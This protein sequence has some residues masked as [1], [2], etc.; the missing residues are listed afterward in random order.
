MS[1]KNN[2]NSGSQQSTWLPVVLWIL[3]LLAINIGLALFSQIDIYWQQQEQIADARQEVEALAAGSDFSY[4]YARQAGDFASAFKSATEVGFSDSKLA[5]FLADRADQVFRKPFPDYELYTFKIP[6]K[7]RPGNLL[8]IKT[9]TQPSRRVMVR[10][11]EHL[12]RVNQGHDISDGAG[13]QNERL[14]SGLFGQDTKSDVLAHSQ[15]GKASFVL[16]RSFP[17]WF[18]WDY[19]KTADGTT[20]GYYLLSQ[21][22]EEHKIAGRLLALRDLRQRGNGLGAFLPLFSGYGGTA[23]QPPLHKSRMFHEWAKNQK[24]IAEK[25]LKQWLESGIPEVARI[26]NYL[27]FSHIGKGQTHLAVF[28][29]PQIKVPKQPLWLYLF[30]MASVSLLLLILLRGILL[31]Q[32]PEF[33]LRFR[34]IMTYL[35]A[36]TLPLSLLIISSYAYIAQYRRATH[37]EILNSLQLSIKQF[38]TRKSQIEDDYRTAFNSIFKDD[39]LGKILV[40]QGSKS[41]AAKAL[42]LHHFENDK[43][44]LPLLC[45]AIIDE[46]GDGT[47]YYGGQTKSEADPAIDTFSYPITL[48][49]REKIKAH[50]PAAKLDKLEASAIQ[51]TSVEAYKSMSRSSLP[52]EMDIRRSFPIKRQ[53]GAKTATQMHDFIWVDGSEKYAVFVVWDDQA[54]DKSTFTNSL[55]QIALNNPDQNFIA[56]KASPQG[57]SFLEKPGRH[58]NGHFINKA[59][60]LATMAQ[61]R[62]SYASRQ[63]NDF[64]L[65]AMPAKKYDQ[66]IIVGG[67]NHFT[68]NRA[69]DHRLFILG[70]I[71][72]LSLAVVILAGYYS[73]RLILDPIETL[74]SAIDKVTGGQLTT[75]IESHS[76]DELGTLCREFSTM[77]IGLRER[78]RLATLL[79]DQAMDA[80][81]KTSS[82]QQILENES[83]SGVALVSDIRNFTGLCEDNP[84]DKVTELLNEHFAGMASIISNHGGRIYKFIGDA[85]EA[86]FPENRNMPEDA[87]TRA[88]NA[89]AMMLLKARQINQLRAKKKLFGYRIGIGLAYGMM[90]SGS[91]GS[92]DTRLDYAIIGEPLKLA[93]KLEALSIHN[94]AFPLIVDEHLN[95]S[96]HGQGLIFKKFDNIDGHAAFSLQEVGGE[97]EAITMLHQKENQNIEASVNTDKIEKFVVDS[98]K[99]LSDRVSFALGLA[100]IIAIVG[101]TLFATHIRKNAATARSKSLAADANQRLL[102]QVRSEKAALTGFESKCRKLLSG[103]EKRASSNPDFIRTELNNYLKPAINE[104]SKE[105]IA[106]RMAVFMTEH[107]LATGSV[108]CNSKLAFAHGWNQRQVNLLGKQSALNYLNFSPKT[109]QNLG[110]EHLSPVFTS[111]LGN[112]INSDMLHYEMLSKATE[113]FPQSKKEYFY[114][115]YIVTGGDTTRKGAFSMCDDAKI[116]GYI[117]LA[118]SAEKLKSSISHLIDSYETPEQKLA[119][120]SPK[121]L[122]ICADLFPAELKQKLNYNGPMPDYADGV[123]N[124]S[125]IQMGE[126]RFRLVAYSPLDE[127]SLLSAVP[128]YLFLLILTG[129]ILHFWWKTS[130]GETFVNTSLTAKL[131]LALLLASIVPLTTVYFVFGLYTDENYSVSISKERSELH[132]FIDLFELR[133][134]FT[135]PLAWKIIR[136]WSKSNETHKNV[137]QV[138]KEFLQTK[139]LSSGSTKLLDKMFSSWFDEYKKIDSKLINFVPKDVVIAGNGWTHVYSGN[140]GSG[141]SDFATMLQGI[142]KNVASKRINTE[143]KAGIDT[144]AVQGELIVESGLQTVRSLFGDDVFVSMAHRVEAPVMMSA[145]SGTIGII[146]H[147]VPDIKEPEYLVLWMVSFDNLTYLYRLASR[148]KNNHEIFASVTHRH[149]QILTPWMASYRH[150]LGLIGAWVTS[151][152]LPV[153]R[154]IERAGEWYLVEARPGIAQLSSFLVAATPEAPI[155]AEL[156]KNRLIFM[157]S[158]FL[159]IALILLIARNAANDILDPVESLIRGMKFASCENYTYRIGMRRGDELGMLCNSFDSMM[160]DLEEKNLMGRMLSKSALT[161][162]SEN[163]SESST[164]EFVFL[165][166]GIPSFAE[167]VGGSSVEQMFIDLKEQIAL[168]SGFIIEEGG[169]IDKIIGDK[170]LAAFAVNGSLADAVESAYNAAIKIISAESKANL[171]FPVA[172]GINSGKVITGLLGVGEKRDFTVIGDAVNVSARIE[173]VAESLRYQRCLLS[174]NVF[175]ALKPGLE[176]REYGEVELKGKAKPI[177]VYQLSI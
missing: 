32:W 90:H 107:D 94:P 167:W 175:A 120:I 60:E 171:P 138:N 23:F 86:V 158:M 112:Q 136:D 113:I 144:S 130:S 98:G 114:W 44:K 34:F 73:A 149:G 118:I 7:D 123:V 140:D 83:F 156:T 129:S 10:T 51:K 176:A 159:S 41:E 57:L 173:N 9:G 37:S 105:F 121:N 134:S 85:I 63:Y 42:I 56:F 157:I 26:G 88:F 77:A 15:K 146:T 71:L 154:R 160:R 31:G 162:T 150:E 6:S 61:F 133:E 84:P 104:S 102:E 30:N 1:K 25:N 132:R 18:L 124:A 128:L 27:A 53:L 75:G 67:T 135:D 36:T 152:N 68:L 145:I 2:S 62:G 142:A 110:K 131:W 16:Y 101:G 147:M 59:R 80:I 21:L 55:N 93:G 29:A 48:M 38:D 125:H 45:F 4:Q 17:S 116:I 155:Q 108:T 95:R 166:I 151:G 43:L 28:L 106:D 20:F 163:N 89:A 126:N 79:S 72:L 82:G 47:R 96:L 8:H 170:M 109:H 103:I 70:I 164:G 46:N 139:H 65:V 78:K 66:L 33:N 76:K 115:D 54:L 92:I 24:Y 141:P 122:V 99:T 111:I 11:F 127:E 97:V 13:Q 174:E 64:S 169:D 40:E 81:T 49:I 39:E 165:Y 12:V 143:I 3:P 172:I 74:K 22:G 148:Y 119:F 5:D 100:L 14:L 91:I 50:N 69:I 87:A 168:I 35:L 153:S 52:R 137:V 19:F 58:V 177:K 161:F 117:A